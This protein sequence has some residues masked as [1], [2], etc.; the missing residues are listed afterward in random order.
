MCE[1]EAFVWSSFV[2]NLKI[3]TAITMKGTVS[4]LIWSCSHDFTTFNLFSWSAE[5]APN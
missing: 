5:I 4:G 2:K 3:V 1:G